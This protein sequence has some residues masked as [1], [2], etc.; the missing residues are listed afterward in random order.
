MRLC[1]PEHWDGSHDSGANATL[2]QPS[3]LALRGTWSLLCAGSVLED[4]HQGMVHYHLPGDDLSWAKVSTYL[5]IREH[6]SDVVHF[7]SS[8]SSGSPIQSCCNI[9]VNFIENFDKNI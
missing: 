7:Q 4:E 5:D 1:I 8:A 3:S 6:T 9:H 2:P